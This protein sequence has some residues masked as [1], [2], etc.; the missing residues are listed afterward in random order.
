VRLLVI[1][2]GGHAKVVI[3]AALCAG[4]EIAGI[5]GREGDPEE[6]LGIPVSHDATDIASDGSSS[7]SAT[8]PLEPSTST[9]TAP[10]ASSPQASSTPL[11]SSQRE[12]TS[13]Q[14]HS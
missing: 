14:A 3:D 10:M 9:S 2:A 1:G 11:P 7:P 8:T 6:L 13:A 4:F 12:Y 5:V